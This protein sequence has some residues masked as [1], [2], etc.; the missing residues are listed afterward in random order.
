MCVL[1]LLRAIK[2]CFDKG[3]VFQGQ[4]PSVKAE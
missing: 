1:K 4:V 3:E 2:D